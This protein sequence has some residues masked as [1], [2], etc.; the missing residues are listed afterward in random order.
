MQV[1]EDLRPRIDQ[2]QDLQGDDLSEAMKEL[3]KALMENPA[4]TQLLLPEDIG[5]LVEAL[6]RITGEAITSAATKPK[7]E[8]AKPLSAEELAAAFEEL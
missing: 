3:K 1:M 7:K 6:R 4:A 2:L 8:K 5:K